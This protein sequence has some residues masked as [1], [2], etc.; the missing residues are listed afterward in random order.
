MNCLESLRLQGSS[1][2]R[3]T[4]LSLFLNELPLKRSQRF[5]FLV[6]SILLFLNLAP[7]R[8]YQLPGNTLLNTVSDYRYLHTRFPIDSTRYPTVI[9]LEKFNECSVKKDIRQ[10]P[11]RGGIEL[12]RQNLKVA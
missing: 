8:I 11:R 3:T 7:K 12:L 4:M 9:V 5:L 6:N 10:S 1:F 2:F